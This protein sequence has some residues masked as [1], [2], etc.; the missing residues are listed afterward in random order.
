MNNDFGQVFRAFFEVTV[1][2]CACC[3]RFLEC[4]E[5]SLD[6]FLRDLTLYVFSL[7][8]LHAS[9][10]YKT[11]PKSDRYVDV[12]SQ[13]LGRLWFVHAPPTPRPVG[14][15]VPRHQVRR[16]YNHISSN[17]DYA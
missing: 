11:P 5:S 4:F 15:K 3:M 16:K 8:D 12:E 10:Q 6:E 2:P 13:V 17:M 1:V 14:P 9:K 7:V